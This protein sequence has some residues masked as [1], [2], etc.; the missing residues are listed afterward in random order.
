MGNFEYR[1][2][3]YIIQAKRK[4]K[5]QAWTDWTL[6][7]NYDDAVKHAKKIKEIGYRS[8]IVDKGENPNE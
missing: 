3:R 6:V 4:G 7:D 8:R 2:K 1:Y 5:N